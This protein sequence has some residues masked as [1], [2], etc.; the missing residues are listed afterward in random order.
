MKG[1]HVCLDVRYNVESGASSYIRNVVPEIL[2]RD[3]TNR[4][5]I[6]RNGSEKLDLDEFDVEVVVAPGSSD[7]SQL[8]WSISVLPSVL[9]RR[10]VDVY[11]AMKMPGPVWA[12]PAVINTMHSIFDPYKGEFPVDLRTR[13]FLKTFGNP[14]VRRSDR[15]IAVSEFVKDCLVDQYALEESI[16]D[17]IYHGVDPT[18][19]VLG[20]EVI[21]EVLQ[22]E[23]IPRRFVLSVGNVVKVK[24]HVSA[25]RAF[26]A[27][28]LPDDAVL[29][30]AGRAD[31]EYAEVVKREVSR[32]GLD[33]RVRFL[34]FVGR[35]TLNA[36]MQSATVLLFPSLT[37][38]CPVTM[39]EAFQCGLPVIA[40][41]RGGL[42]DV[43]RDVARFVEDPHDYNG[44]ADILRTLWTD[45]ETRE[46]MRLRSLNKV[47]EF[48]WARSADQHIA[49][50]VCAASTAR[51]G[52][53]HA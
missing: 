30:I 35:R 45:D 40:S 24:N 27:A 28:S 8:L 3:R 16:I 6:V 41:K 51:N 36:L 20:K 50:Y 19:E 22:E 33:H 1:I 4:Y 31:G 43:G 9:K 25:V 21:D 15:I 34:G 17:V 46:A 13:V 18:F 37:E 52:V 38:G 23:E 26:A 42:W 5:L 32:L 49:A 29:V 2:T 53:V 10:G 12:A 7:M 39:L 47:R 44:F 14:M 11:H 48:S